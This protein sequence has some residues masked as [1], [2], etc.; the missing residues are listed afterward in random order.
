MDDEKWILS[1]HLLVQIMDTDTG[2]CVVSR[3]DGMDLHIDGL[4]VRINVSGQ[5]KE[6]RITYPFA[7]NE[8]HSIR[9]KLQVR[10]K[11]VGWDNL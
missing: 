11:A 9:H 4:S 5:S 6:R 10:A 2:Y 3:N 7:V 1:D 8:K